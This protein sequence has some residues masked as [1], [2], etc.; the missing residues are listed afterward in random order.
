MVV[1]DLFSC[2]LGTDSHICAVFSLKKQDVI[3]KHKALFYK[4]LNYQPLTPLLPYRNG[5]IKIY[6]ISKKSLENNS[7]QSNLQRKKSKKVKSLKNQLL[8]LKRF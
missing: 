6:A 3:L 4:T 1:F 8:R 5:W 2:F 7:L